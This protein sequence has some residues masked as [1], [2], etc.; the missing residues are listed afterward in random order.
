M[1]AS[2][3]AQ[4][5]WHVDAD[6][7]GD[8]A[9]NDPLIGDP[10]EDGSVDHPFDAIQEGLN[11]ARDGDT[12]RVADGIYSGEGNARLYVGAG[13]GGLP[14]RFTLRSANGPAACVIDGTLQPGWTWSRGIAGSSLGYWPSVGDPRF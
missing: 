10:L 4:T 13:P 5:T 8:P 1:A 12:V 2:V 3:S 9:P 6:A 14:R 11:R 7:P